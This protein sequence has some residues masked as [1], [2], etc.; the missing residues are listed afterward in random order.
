MPLKKEGVK[1]ARHQASVAE[2]KVEAHSQNYQKFGDLGALWQHH[3]K[4]DEDLLVGPDGQAQ[5]LAGT[6]SGL[7]K[8]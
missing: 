2:Y 7:S 1:P 8:V 6:S 3:G 4:S 5:T